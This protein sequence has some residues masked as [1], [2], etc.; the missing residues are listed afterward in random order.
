MEAVNTKEISRKK[1][2]KM[3]RKYKDRLDFD[4]FT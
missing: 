2:Q 4:A 1:V 3:R